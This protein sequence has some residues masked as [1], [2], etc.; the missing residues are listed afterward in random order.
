MYR[1]KGNHGPRGVRMAT[2]VVAIPFPAPSVPQGYSV[3]ARMLTI[4]A[5][6]VGAGLVVF[7]IAGL[8]VAASRGAEQLP[9]EQ[10]AGLLIDETLPVVE[11]ALLKGP[12]S[13]EF[14]HFFLA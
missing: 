14:D 2:E 1:M 8:M 6:G 5:A 7:G 13:H 4:L 11:Y 3:R 9:G 10:S 12:G